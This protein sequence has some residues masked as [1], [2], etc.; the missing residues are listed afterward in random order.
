MTLQVKFFLVNLERMQ[1]LQFQQRTRK[2]DLKMASVLRALQA[3][4]AMALKR[5]AAV[6]GVSTRALCLA[7]AHP[8]NA[9]RFA[10]P[11]PLKRV[12][13]WVGGEHEAGRAST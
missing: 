8:T 7:R 12:E 13:R 2:H 3:P 4:A 5:S 11:C 1:W 6:A 10:P 9:L